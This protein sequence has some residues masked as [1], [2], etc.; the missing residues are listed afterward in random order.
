MWFW[1][2]KKAF[3][4]NYIGVLKESKRFHGIS[5]IFQQASRVSGGF[6]D[7]ITESKGFYGLFRNVFRNL[8][9]IS[10]NFGGCEVRFRGLRDTPRNVV[11]VSGSLKGFHGVSGTF[12]KCS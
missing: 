8:R 11:D 12:M 10:G 1:K 4:G 2:V 7:F 6:K 9:R 3:H 5:K